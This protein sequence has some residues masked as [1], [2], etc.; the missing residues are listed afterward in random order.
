MTYFHKD[1][2]E[3]LDFYIN[4]IVDLF[5]LIQGKLITLESFTLEVVF[6]FF[7]VLIIVLH[8]CPPQQ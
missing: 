6:V 7:F 3:E 8:N 4:W 1:K 2:S 5:P